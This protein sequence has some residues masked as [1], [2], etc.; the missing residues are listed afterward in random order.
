MKKILVTGCTSGI[1][2]EIARE[3]LKRGD[4]LIMVNRSPRKSQDVID[5]LRTVYPN[6]SIVLYIIDLS[7]MEEIHVVGTT[8]RQA[9]PRIDI[10]IN[11]AGAFFSKRTLCVQG[12]EKTFCVNHMGYFALSKELLPCLEGGHARIVNVASR[13]HHYGDIDIAQLP[14]PVRYQAQRA[15]G[16]SKL[17]NILFT[18]ELA[19]RL[20]NKDI[21]VN[22]LHPGVVRTG[23]AQ[24][25][26]GYFAWGFRLFRRFFL[27]AEEGAQT[28]LFLA[29][30]PSI[31]KMSGGYYAR[32]TLQKTSKRAQ[33][34]ILAKKLWDLS[35]R[36]YLEALEAS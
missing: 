19:R 23:F 35:E 17:C 30:H 13:A 11:N 31:K 1:G 26:G 15:Y 29:Y 21:S 34:P 9:H 33:D 8:I 22:C 7:V 4:T 16:T 5:S 20:E 14:L 12:W 27:S 18:K 32:C 2:K 25:Q 36:L 24:D 3:V 6:A 10:L 28:P